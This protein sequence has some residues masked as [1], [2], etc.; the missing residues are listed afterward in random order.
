MNTRCRGLTLIELMVTIAIVAILA[1]VAFPAM[2]EFIDRQRLVGQTQAI[3]DMAQT[4]RSEVIKRR[5]TTA[6]GGARQ[7]VM[8]VQGGSNWY[9]GLSHGTAACVPNADP[10]L[11]TC[12][13]NSGVTDVETRQLV[14]KG[15]ATSCPNCTMAAP[16]GQFLVVFD[17]Q[18]LVT[19]GGGQ[20]ITLRSPQGRELSVRISPLGRISM[21]SPGGTVTGY[22]ACV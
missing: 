20:P 2:T 13:L 5:A 14:S 15:N 12:K 6:G 11:D 21:C 8:T 10:A 3:A 1:G 7:V 16:V 18:G 19:Q 22:Q 4:A 9:V 17:Y